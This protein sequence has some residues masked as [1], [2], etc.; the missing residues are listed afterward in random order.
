MYCI[1][2]GFLRKFTGYLQDP[3]EI[4]TGFLQDLVKIFMFL[5][6]LYRVCE[7]NL[8]AIYKIL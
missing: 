7:L 3:L 6:E 5:Y 8:Q 2:T 4:I 1:F